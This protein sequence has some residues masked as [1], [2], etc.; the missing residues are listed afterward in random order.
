VEIVSTGGTARTLRE[1]GLPVV[2]V[3]TLTGSP[4]ILDGRVKT[5]HPLVHAGILYRRDVPTDVARVEADGIPPIDLVVVN[6]YDF[7]ETIS[8][9]DVSLDAALEKIDIGGPTM[10]RAAAKNWPHVVALCDV[11]DYDAVVAEI[12]E[13]G[14]GAETRRVLAARAFARTASYDRAIAGYLG[15]EGGER[16][17]LKMRTDVWTLDRVLRYGENPHQPGA[18]FVPASE[19]VVRASSGVALAGLEQVHGKRTSYNNL[20][21]LDAG[22]RL[23]Q[24]LGP[25]AAV[26]IKHRNPCGAATGADPLTAFRRAWSGDTLSAF[27]GVVVLRGR[28]DHDLALALAENF[29]EVVAAEAFDDAA[30]EVLR[31]KKRLT[32]LASTGLGPEGERIPEE[33]EEMRSVAGGELVQATDRPEPEDALGFD[34]VTARAP[35]DDESRALR[36]AWQVVRYV[37]SNAIVFAD[38]TRTVG[39]GSGQTSRV[40]AVNVAIMKAGREGHSLGGTVMASDA[41][42]P[43]GDSVEAAARVGCTAV[44]QPGGSKRDAESIEAADAANIAMV[45]TGRRCFRH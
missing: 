19:D 18:F 1:A 26:V 32:L 9:A 31:K 45:F 34:V 36:F 38:G 35:T 22:W 7:E 12:R 20:L 11:H 30:L 41:F 10:L 39:I 23:A 43:F 15:D 42:F 40:D 17:W 3:S 25:R 6:L 5:L 24:A 16:A 2:S 13:G 4:E 37:Q 28:V 29:V 8:N 33:S 44:I 21:D 27:G 14:V